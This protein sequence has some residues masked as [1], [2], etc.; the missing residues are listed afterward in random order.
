MA[1]LLSGIPDFNTEELE[2]LLRDLQIPDATR[3]PAGMTMVEAVEVSDILLYVGF[4]LR[5][6][7]M[8]HS[9][10]TVLYSIY[11]IYYA[12]YIA[13]LLYSIYVYAK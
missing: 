9:M 7:T 3:N 10:Y 1:A 5:L 12:C 11:V 6:L 8:V 2:A 4:R 13:L